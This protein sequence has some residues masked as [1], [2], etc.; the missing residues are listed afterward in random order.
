[1]NDDLYET[2]ERLQAKVAS[3]EK[4]VQDLENQPQ[5]MLNERAADLVGKAISK[6]M[7]HYE[8]VTA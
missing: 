8:T 4:R 3:L 6:A 1:M 2:I 7:E 5:I